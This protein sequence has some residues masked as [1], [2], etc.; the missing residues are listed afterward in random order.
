MALSN[1]M[2]VNINVTMLRGGLYWYFISGSTDV[3]NSE[4]FAGD[5][6]VILIIP[7][8]QF[9]ENVTAYIILGL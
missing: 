8:L 3:V 6:T 5:H 2:M 4:V 7:C 9:R 1:P